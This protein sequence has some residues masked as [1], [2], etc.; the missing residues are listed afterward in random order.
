MQALAEAGI[1]TGVLMMPVLPFLEDSPANVRGVVEAAAAHGAGYV[2]PGFGV[3]L[4]DR[5][6]DHFYARLDAHFPGVRARYEQR[7]G[8]RYACPPPNVA[9]L[10]AVFAEACQAHGLQTAV[11]RYTP[12]PAAE[13]LPLL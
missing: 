1:P 2:L 13:Q 5:Q 3:T 4:R 11:P 7:Y 10:A 9:E 6:R 8:E 12:T